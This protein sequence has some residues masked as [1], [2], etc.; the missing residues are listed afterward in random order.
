MRNSDHESNVASA[1]FVRRWVEER[2]FVWLVTEEVLDA[3]QCPDPTPEAFIFPDKDGD[4]MDTGNYRKRVLH[5]LAAELELPKLTSRSYSAPL[6]R[7]PK[8]EVR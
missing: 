5:K 7:W 1:A 8:R 2:T 3:R 4:F 6:R